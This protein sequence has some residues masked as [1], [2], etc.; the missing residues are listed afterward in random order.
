M[1]SATLLNENKLKTMTI[2]LV[3]N[4]CRNLKLFINKVRLK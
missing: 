3:Y 4:E 1:L 2:I